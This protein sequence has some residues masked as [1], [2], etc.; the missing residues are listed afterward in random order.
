MDID[1]WARGA[2]EHEFEANRYTD[3]SFIAAPGF[4]FVV[5]GAR[6]PRDSLV[7]TVGAK[8][9]ITKNASL[10]G[11]FEGQFG[12]EST[13]VGGTGGIVISW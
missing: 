8:L 1:V 13:S 4:D 7:T 12:W 11:T 5:Q 2:W 10:F 6:P 3:S 9:A